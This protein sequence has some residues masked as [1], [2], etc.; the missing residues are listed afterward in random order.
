MEKSSI[1]SGTGL[2][3]FTSREFNVIVECGPHQVDRVGRV[4]ALNGLLA[5]A[6]GTDRAVRLH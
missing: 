1:T 2:N 5:A 6:G 4:V 3:H